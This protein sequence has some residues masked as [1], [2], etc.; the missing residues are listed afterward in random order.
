MERRRERSSDPV[1]TDGRRESVIVNFD[2]SF[3]CTAVVDSIIFILFSAKQNTETEGFL[4]F[5]VSVGPCTL[6]V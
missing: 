3:K 5:T 2:Q 1:E 4:L 6:L